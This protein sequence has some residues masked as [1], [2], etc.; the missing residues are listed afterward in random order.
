ME[1]A[2][3]FAA[4]LKQ[5]QAALAGFTALLATDLLPFDETVADGLRNGQ[6]QKF[7]YCAELA[8]KSIRAFLLVHDGVEVQSPKAAMKAFYRLNHLN[9]R[10]YELAIELVE[11]RNLMSHLYQARL[12]DQVYGNLPQYAV[13]LQGIC[14]RLHAAAQHT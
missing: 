4:K 10:E 12:F 6:L 13:L 5:F 11:A 14:E 3:A 8:W 7:E 1:Q 2:G 9:E